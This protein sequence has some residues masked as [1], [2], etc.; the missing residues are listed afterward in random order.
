[1]SDYSPVSV[2][3]LWHSD[4]KERT[5]PHIACFLGNATRMNLIFHRAKITTKNGSGQIMG[6]YSRHSPSVK[7]H[8]ETG[9]DLLQFNIA[10]RPEVKRIFNIKKDIELDALLYLFP[11]QFFSMGDFNML[12]MKQHNLHLKTMMD[13]GYIEVAIEAK[14]GKLL[15]KKVYTLTKKAKDCVIMYYRMLSGESFDWPEYVTPFE[16]KKIDRLRDNLIEKFKR[17]IETTPH[18]FKGYLPK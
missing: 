6:K 1:M 14:G 16:Q 4:K 9:Y 15:G 18:K 12:P 17:Q 3:P 2:E 5:L 7:F 8:F 10:V 11:I 13:L